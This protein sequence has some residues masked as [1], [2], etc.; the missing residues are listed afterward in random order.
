M[1]QSAARATAHASAAKDRSSLYE[2]I[3]NKIIAQ[4]KAGRARE[5]GEQPRG[6]PF[7]KRFTVFNVEQCA[8]LPDGIAAPPPAIDTSLILPQVEELI[9]ATGADFRVGGDKAYN[10]VAGDYIRVPP[11][12]AFFEPVN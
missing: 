3:T 1:P 5:R 8:G 6:I 11:P 9:R 12:Q 10:D 2:E 4:L 7:L